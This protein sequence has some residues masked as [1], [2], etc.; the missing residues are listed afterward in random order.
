[1]HIPI[2]KKMR[3]RIIF[4]WKDS[5]TW[6][7]FPSQP[8]ASCARIYV[9][10]CRF[11]EMFHKPASTTKPFKLSSTLAL[12]EV[13]QLSAVL[14]WTFV[15]ALLQHQPQH[16][17]RLPSDHSR[18]PAAV[19]ELC[20]SDILEIAYP[21]QF[22]RLFSKSSVVSSSDP[23]CPRQKRKMYRRARGGYV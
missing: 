1:M 15:R 2:A 8:H 12:N 20:S 18:A 3:T 23:A 13:V 14:S 22:F 5:T 17:I 21:A 19:Y 9:H 4:P 16:D 11:P 6:S 7:S 10:F